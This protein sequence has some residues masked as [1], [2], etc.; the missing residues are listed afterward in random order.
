MGQRGPKPKTAAEHALSNNWRS[1][2]K[3]RDAVVAPEWATKR[4]P[5]LKGEA[6]AAWDHAVESLAEMNILSSA[7]AD[8]LM[9]YAEA[10]G[11][12]IQA[13]KKMQKENLVVEGP[14][15][16]TYANPLI[17]IKQKAAQRIK[18]FARQFGL[19][20]EARIGVKAEKP[21]DKT[22]DKTRFFDRKA[23]A[24]GTFV[25]G[26]KGKKARAAGAG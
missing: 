2:A 22:D 4:P 18:D 6:A 17:G 21:K 13:A 8:A 14:G 1:K 11:E 24:P 10:V 19:T 23:P 9:A 25:G 7:D 3:A 12:F 16:N 15:G 5:F 20:P 26:A